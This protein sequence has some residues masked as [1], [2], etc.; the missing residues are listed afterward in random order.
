VTP[1][2]GQA[3]PPL[4]ILTLNGAV[5]VTPQTLSWVAA[6]PAGVLS[7]SFIRGGRILIR[8][9]CGFLYDAKRRPFSAALDAILQQMDTLHL[10]GGVL[11]SWFF[12]KG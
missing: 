4:P 1:A 9:H 7:E 12:V 10:P 11:E 6:T 5:Q 3:G 2:S 8:I